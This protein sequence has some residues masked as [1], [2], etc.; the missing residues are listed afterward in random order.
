M[1][2]EIPEMFV[3]IMLPLVKKVSGVLAFTITCYGL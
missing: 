3:T 2:A 1:R